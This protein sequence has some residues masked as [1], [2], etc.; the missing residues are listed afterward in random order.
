MTFPAEESWARLRADPRIS[1][2]PDVPSIE[3]GVATPVSAVRY[4]LGADGEARLLIP[5]A[6]GEPFPDVDA[7]GLSLLDTMLRVQG[8]VRFLDITCRDPDLERVFATVCE[9]MLARLA[10]GDRPG[11]AVIDVIRETRELLLRGLIREIALETALGLAGELLVLIDLLRLAPGAWRAWVG[12]TP[13]ARHDFRAGARALE[14]KTSLRA[15]TQTVEISAIDQLVEPDGGSLRLVH[16]IL[17]RDGAGPVSVDSLAEQ[18]LRLADDPAGLQARLAEAGFEPVL[19][20]LWAEHRFAFLGR[21]A[22]RVEDGFPRLTPSNFRERELPLGV[23]R[24]RYRVDLA[25][26]RAFRLAQ[27]AQTDMLR[28]FC[29]CL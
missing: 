12:P 8:P 26:A 14:V 22:Y 6:P 11:R 13:A 15:Q 17:E 3:G 10:D 28:E 5:L 23:S 29:A 7:P 27:E 4:A 25:Q 20:S 2:T 1:T 16:V 24:F 18:A 9:G 19:A 21:E